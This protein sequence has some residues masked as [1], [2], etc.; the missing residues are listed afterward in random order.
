MPGSEHAERRR[1]R[2]MWTT[3][4]DRQVRREREQR[5]ATPATA[6]P[7]D[8][9]E[10]EHEAGARSATAGSRAGCRRARPTSWNGS[11]TAAT[12][13]ALELVEAEDLLVEDR[14]RAMPRPTSDDGEERQR[15]TRCAAASGPASRCATPRRSDGGASSVRDGLL[16][17]RPSARR[18]WSPADRLAQA[19]R[20]RRPRA[21]RVGIEKTRNGARQ[22]NRNGEAAPPSERAEDLADASWRRGGSRRP[23]AAVGLVVVGEQRV[24]GRV[25]DRAADGRPDAGERPAARSIGAKPGEEREHAPRRGAAER[26]CAPGERRSA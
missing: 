24:V 7:D 10:P 18:S 19:W 8:G 6:T 4:G 23:R 21:R 9:E 1:R 12:T 3:I 22:P 20:R 16:G 5:P 25:V 17:R 26:R 11:A 13:P 15:R 2:A 14:R